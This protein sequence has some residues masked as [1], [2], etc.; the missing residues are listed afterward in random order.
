MR[1]KV[2]LEELFAEGEHAG[3]KQL[4]IVVKADVQGS[5]E[6]LR[7]ALTELST[8]AVEVKVVL[9]GVG[10]VTESDV[11]LARASEAIVIGFHVRPDSAARRAADSQGVDIRHYRIIYEATDDLR[12]AM[13]GLLPPTLEE[14]V[15]GQAEVRQT[16]TVPRV[17]TIAGCFVTEGLVRRNAQCR[18]L[19]DAVEIYSGRVGSLRRFKD[20]ARE[21]QKDFE[22]GIGI[23]GYND[24]KISDVIEVFEVEEK[25]ATL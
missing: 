18:L 5:V 22:C 9:A 11:M 15:L 7:D 23:E 1:P 6:A 10:G 20:D 17:G 12:L 3:P 4:S 24:I 2:T 21:V 13:A 19:R 25:P 14:T 8:D 16:F